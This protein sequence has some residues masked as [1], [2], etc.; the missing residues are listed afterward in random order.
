MA[1]AVETVVVLCLMVYAGLQ[2]YYGICYDIPPVKYILNVMIIVLIYAL[3]SFLQFNP[4]LVNRLPAELC[5]G[6]IRHWSLWMLRWVKLIF[7]GSLLIPCI[8][9]AAGIT[10]RSSYSA[11]VIMLLIL[12]VVYFECRILNEIKNMNGDE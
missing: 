2:I 11:I 9:D 7:I 4:E 8:A 1:I 10:I 12:F 3:L 6:R 5:T